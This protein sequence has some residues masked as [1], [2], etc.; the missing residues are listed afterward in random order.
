MK[1]TLTIILLL[2]LCLGCCACGEQAAESA[3][4]GLEIVTTVFPAYD[5]ARQIAGERA[6]VT[7]LVPPGAEAHSFEPTAQDMIRVQNAALFVYNGGE[8]EAWVE[9]LLEGQDRPEHLLCMLDCVDA[10]EEEHK[11]GMQDLHEEEEDEEEPE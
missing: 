4:T 9:E 8:S 2:C 10:L 11:E 3:E 5:F 6:Q 1:K 7:L